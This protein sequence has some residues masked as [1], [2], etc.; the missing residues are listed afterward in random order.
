[1]LPQI[2]R[3]LYTTSLSDH[4]RVV[5]RQAIS[6]ARAHGAKI[7][8]LH[9]VEPLTHSES[10]LVEA[11]MSPETTE[12][13]KNLAEN[14]R[15]TQSQQ[16]LDRI[17]ARVERFYAEEL[18]PDAHADLVE[19]I[20]VASGSPP[21]VIVRVADQLDADMIVVGREVEGGGWQRAI[22][23]STARQVMQLTARPVLV[24]T[25]GSEESWGDSRS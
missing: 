18:G 3:I 9:V 16:V 12:A 2:Q 7:T 14:L 10:F 6:L 4:T 21:A 23:G 13:T 11:Y 19:N 22:R 17:C 20:M 24:V 8:I 5:F 1:M 25:R 15:Q